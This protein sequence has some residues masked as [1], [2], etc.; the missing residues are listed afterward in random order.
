[1]QESCLKYDTNNANF[2]P[3]L[4]TAK[5]EFTKI[6]Y[7]ELSYKINGILYAVRQELGPYCN[8]KQYCDLIE[9]K[10]INENIKCER[11]KILPVSFEGEQPN[12]NKVDFLIE[13][14]IILEIKAKRF[15]NRDDY[16]QLRRYLLAFDKKLGIIVNF[17]E[18]YIKPKR[19]LNSSTQE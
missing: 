18:K 5:N 17:R 14:R 1:M 8:E 7:P 11:E 9:K 19:I 12:R 2:M 4:R 10:F 16:Y 6:I 3:T 15:L 13:G